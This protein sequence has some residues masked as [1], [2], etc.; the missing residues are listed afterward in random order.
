M[1]LRINNYLA[2]NHIHSTILE[3]FARQ[4]MYSNIVYGK[5]SLEWKPCLIQYTGVNY[6]THTYVI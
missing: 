5:T 6:A 2:Q 4:G 3:L 1:V